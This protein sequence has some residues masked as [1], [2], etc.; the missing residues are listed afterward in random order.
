MV[1]VR[2]FKAVFAASAP[3]DIKLTVE[4][5]YVVDYKDW[6]GMIQLIRSDSKDCP[7]KVSV[8]EFLQAFA[9]SKFDDL[10]IGDED[11]ILFEQATVKKFRLDFNY[12]ASDHGKL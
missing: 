8:A 9:D 1:T 10:A 3:K 2:D 6:N 5:V 7:E 12:A 4:G 11:G